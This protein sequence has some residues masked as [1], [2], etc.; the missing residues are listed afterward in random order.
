MITIAITETANWILRE[1]LP[2]SEYIQYGEIT[3]ILT[4]RLFGIS[5]YKKK[6]VYNPG[7]VPDL[8]IK[9]TKIGY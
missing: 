9:T 7:T 3:K 2:N 6:Y 1:V 5:L 4:V 8:K